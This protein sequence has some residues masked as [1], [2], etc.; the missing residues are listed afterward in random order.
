MEMAIDEDVFIRARRYHREELERMLEGMYPTVHRMAHGLTGR[1][2]SAQSIIDFIIK[3][4]MERLEQWRDVETAERWFY[5][6]TVLASRDVGVTTPDMNEDLLV[7]GCPDPTIDYIAFIK[8]VRSL[9]NQQREA[10][11]LTHGEGLS[12]RYLGIAMDCSTK[13]AEMHLQAAHESLEPI[14]GEHFVASRDRLTRAYA[15]AAPSDAMVRPTITDYVGKMLLPRRLRKIARM[16]VLL[17]LL[18]LTLW[19]AWSLRY[20][21]PLLN[22]FLREIKAYS[23]AVK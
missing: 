19:V 16:T 7:T 11:I 5:H 20:R 21:I 4:A 22:E 18:A 10:F 9:P 2:D 3:H 13:A 8:A 15:A 23:A 14:S 1:A 17:G 6:H 12:T